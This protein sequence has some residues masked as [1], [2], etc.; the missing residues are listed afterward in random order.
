MLIPD[1]RMLPVTAI[2]IPPDRVS[3][4]S[5]TPQEYLPI[6]PVFI[7]AYAEAKPTLEP[8]LTLTEN[9]P[10]LLSNLVKE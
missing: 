1:E 4:D 5:N 2:P 10:E 8:V 6:P 7:P 3:V 9:L